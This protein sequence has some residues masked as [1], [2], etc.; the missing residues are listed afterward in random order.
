MLQREG[1][2]PFDQLLQKCLYPHIKHKY[3]HVCTKLVQILK[4]EYHLMEYLETMRVNICRILSHSHDFTGG[5]SINSRC[6][7][8]QHI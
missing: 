3:N 1:L 6:E 8:K 7:A 2:Q 5:G 4:E